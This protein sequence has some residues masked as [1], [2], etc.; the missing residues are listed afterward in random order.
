MEVTRAESFKRVK[1]TSITLLT[2]WHHS[3]AEAYVIVEFLM[4]PTYI[5]KSDQINNLQ[6]D[7]G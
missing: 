2:R 1:N 6:H 5:T 3:L 4:T 7:S